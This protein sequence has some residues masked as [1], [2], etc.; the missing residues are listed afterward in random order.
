VLGERLSAVRR[1]GAAIALGGAAVV[2]AG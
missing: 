1:T 2:A